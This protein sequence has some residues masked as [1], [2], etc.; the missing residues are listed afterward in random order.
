[1][2][3]QRLF[4]HLTDTDIFAGIVGAL[5]H[6]FDHPGF[7][8]A[9]MINS[10][11]ELAIRYNDSSVLENHHLSST[12]QLLCQE[13]YNIFENCSAEAYKEVRE[14]IIR[15][16][17]ATDFSKHFEVLGQFKSKL[18]SGP[19]EYSKLEDRRLV[20]CVALKCADVSHTAK[21]TDMHLEWTN[22]VTE[23]FYTQGDI[24]RQR[25]LPLS[26]YMDRKTGDLP[27]SQIGF[28]SFLVLPLYKV[29]CEEFTDSEIC[30][31]CLQANL[32]NWKHKSLENE[33]KKS[34]DP[35]QK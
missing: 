17:L 28:I 20:L 15:I 6:D 33:A 5:C 3:R 1:M 9:F 18:A 29:W 32:D 27:K 35:T 13:Q 11:D 14:T 12:F 23:E 26:P 19:L 21:S 25:N 4:D 10:K 7:N 24:E 16:V 2:T 34:K 22:R 8:N 31:T 30:L